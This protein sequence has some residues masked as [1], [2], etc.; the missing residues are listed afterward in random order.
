MHK[1]TFVLT[2]FLTIAAAVIATINL[3]NLIRGN[4]NTIQVGGPTPPGLPSPTTTIQQY[5]QFRSATCGVNLFYPDNYQVK[6]E[7]NSTRI[8][9]R[10]NSD[11]IVLACQKEIPR[12]PLP[13]NKVETVKI[14]TE[15]ATLYHDGSQKDGA[16]IDRLIFTHPGNKLDVYLAGFGETFDFII[17]KLTI[18]VE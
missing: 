7:G 1:N 12:P 16:P 11:V 14:G 13:T 17:N 6:E 5:R 3:V 10:D 8:A 2:V 9:K 18:G 4:P 15:S